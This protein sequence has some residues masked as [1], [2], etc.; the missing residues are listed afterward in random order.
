MRLQ[1]CSIALT[2]LTAGGLCHERLT[3]GTNTLLH[4]NGD[5]IQVHEKEASTT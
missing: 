2:L 5:L 3:Y 4:L 1:C